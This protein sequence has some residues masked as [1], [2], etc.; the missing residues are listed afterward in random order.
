MIVMVRETGQHEELFVRHP[1]YPILTAADWSY[2][3]NSVFNVFLR[4]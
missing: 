1:G 2:P 4:N 3:V